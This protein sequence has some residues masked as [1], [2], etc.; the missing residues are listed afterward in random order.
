M[1]P[2]GL[3]I[4]V[5]LSS[6]I[7][8]LTAF[9]MP[10][11]HRQDDFFWSGLGFFYALILWFCASQFTG[12]LLLGQL[13]V[14][15]LLISYSWQ[16]IQLRK[17]LVNPGE[18]KKLDKF[19]VTGFI[20]GFFNR[21]PK[22]QQK[23]EQS[24]PEIV[25]K[26]EPVEEPVEEA[27]EASEAVEEN[28]PIVAVTEDNIL[29][30]TVDTVS[31]TTS[32]TAIE[33]TESKDDILTQ[34]DD[35]VIQSE[36]SDQSSV[37]QDIPAE[38]A[39]EV[40]STIESTSS[41]ISETTEKKSGLFNKLLNFGKKEPKSSPDKTSSENTP[42]LTNTKL[43]ELLDD[44][45]EETKPEVIPEAKVAEVNV[46]ETTVEETI[47]AEA[48]IEEETNWDF[49]D[50]EPEPTPKETTNKEEEL[51]NKSTEETIEQKTSVDPEKPASEEE[52]KQDN[53]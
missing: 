43:D 20:G 33:T 25:E 4:A 15:A 31:E 48:V 23:V 46:E 17:A 7:L 39:T 49:L 47:V 29:D 53:L 30:E 38:T 16:V 9:F 26:E 44:E 10:K 5:G 52:T 19:S 12:T 8:F 34:K 21:S 40:E 42:S 45:E 13:A 6:S 32:E 50:E 36:E 14:V 27:G 51:V 11:I 28:V 24:Q 3:A 2:Y 22:V 18:R 35:T 1:L 37:N 41:S